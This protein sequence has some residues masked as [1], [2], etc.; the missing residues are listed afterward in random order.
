VK[1]RWRDKKFSLYDDLTITENIEFYGGIYGLSRPQIKERKEALIDQVGLEKFTD[2]LTRELP[3]GFKQRL[4]LGCA[5]LHD[6]PIVFLDEPT[7]GVDPEARRG[8]WDLIYQSVEMGKTVFVTTHFMD[9]A[10]YC[11]RV[12]I[13][14][15]GK[16]IAL[17]T[18]RNLKEEYGKANMQDVFVSLVKE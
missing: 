9:E 11:H 5:L 17:D 1:E 3:L 4:A 2:K 12:S 8:F 15:E 7:S 6:P 13:M 14:R 10:E 18:P 16:L